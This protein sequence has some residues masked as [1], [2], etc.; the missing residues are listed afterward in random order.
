MV[1][2]QT[3]HYFRITIYILHIKTIMIISNV[4][5]IGRTLGLLN[6]GQAVIIS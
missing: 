1:K 6:Y 5:A 4:V 2:T 3:N